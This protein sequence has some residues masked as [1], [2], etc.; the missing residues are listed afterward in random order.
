MVIYIIKET[1]TK[2]LIKR[3]YFDV[4]G[5]SAYTGIFKPQVGR[6]Q[7]FNCQEI[8]HKAFAYKKAQTCA[9][10]ANKGHHHS[11]CQ[12]VVFKCVLCTGLH[13]SFSKNCRVRLPQSNA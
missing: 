4:A 12:A 13:K 7:C 9:R 10:C 1:D 6:A 2:H 8:G 3:E 5:E 11:T